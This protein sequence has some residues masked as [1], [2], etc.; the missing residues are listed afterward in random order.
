MIAEYLRRGWSLVPVPAGSKAAIAPGWNTRTFTA[1]D[2]SASEN[3]SL[4]LGPRSG[5]I[6]DIDL[7]CCEALALADLY[8][9]PTGAIFGRASKPR[10]HRLYVAPGA[11]FEAFADRADGTMMVELRAA[12]RE[13]GAHLTLL[14][15]S[16]TDGERREWDGETIAPA[17]VTAAGLRARV[18]WLGIGCL[19]MR[20]VS[21]HAARRPG[22]DLP[23]LLHEYDPNLGEMAYAWAGR[24]VQQPLR[25]RAELSRAEIDLAELVHA[26]PNNCDWIEWNKTGMAIYCASQ[27][28]EQGSTVFDNWSAKSSKYNAYATAARWRH[29]HRSPPSRIGVGS[30]VYLAKEAGWQPKSRDA[31]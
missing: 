20:H 3:V 27:G 28:S 6:V 10:S 18:A 24:A 30:L 4:V 22:R 16:V 12:G 31:A 26:I 19:V 23:D 2:F 8:L 7:D 11:I 9:P 14:P 15:P 5:E 25:P 17:I 1:A 21:E 29:Y 13:N